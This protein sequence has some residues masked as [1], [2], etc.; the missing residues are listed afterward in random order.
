MGRIQSHYKTDPLFK[1]SNLMYLFPTILEFLSNI[2][3]G[4]ITNLYWL[5]RDFFQATCCFWQMDMDGQ[6]NLYFPEGID[7][8]F[9]NVGGKMLDAVLLNMRVHGRIAVCGM[10][11][12]YNLDKPEGYP[13]YLDMALAYMREGTI[14]YV[15]DI[16]ESLENGPAALVGLFT[17]R[18]MGK[19]V[20]LVSHEGKK[21]SAK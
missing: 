1:I 16:A 13:K 18:N 10:I 15:E 12:Q 17:G 9:E 7:I 8:Y 5:D 6:V 2:K 11:S 3:Y 14:I 20:V 4:D 19:Q 21:D